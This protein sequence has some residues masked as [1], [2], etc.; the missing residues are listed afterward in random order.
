MANPNIVNVT[1]IFGN[2]T[3]IIPSTTSI[4]QWTTLTPVVGTVNKVNFI[5][6]ANMVLEPVEISVAINTAADGTGTNNHLAYNITIPVGASLV[7]S[8][9]ATSFY[10]GETQSVKVA[11]DTA[12]AVEF[13]ASYESL[14]S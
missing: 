1:E 9:K 11:V 5:I 12:S 3:Y 13:T 10:V 14:T 7:I 4:T 8:D 6:A 2:T